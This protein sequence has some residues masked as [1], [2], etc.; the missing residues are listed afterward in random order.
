MGKIPSKELIKDIESNFTEL[1]NA[2][3]LYEKK[4]IKLFIGFWVIIGLWWIG[5]WC[6]GD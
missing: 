4:D 5:H 3:I 6:I 1:I 2:A